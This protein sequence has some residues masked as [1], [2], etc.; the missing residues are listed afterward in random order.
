[1]ATYVAVKGPKFHDAVYDL[2][3]AVGSGVNVTE[4]GD[5]IRVLEIENPKVDP[6]PVVDRLFESAIRSPTECEKIH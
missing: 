1:M 6:G 3:E 5:G 4:G 2:A